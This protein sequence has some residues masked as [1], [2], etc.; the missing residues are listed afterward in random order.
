MPR[1]NA[2]QP[3][4]PE[5]RILWGRVKHRI[6]VLEPH[7]NSG[8]SPVIQV[9]SLSCYPQLQNLLGIETGFLSYSALHQ[10]QVNHITSG[11][12]ASKKTNVPV[13]FAILI[14][15]VSIPETR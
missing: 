12:M 8:L 5:P 11:N 15:K 13:A 7:R 1:T 2:S 3:S 10:V 6:D 14:G 4:Q 9:L